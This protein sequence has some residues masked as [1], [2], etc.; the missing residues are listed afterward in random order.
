[1]KCQKCNNEIPDN[2]EFCPYCGQSQ[3]SKSAE[4]EKDFVC[5]YCGTEIEESTAYCPECGASFHHKINVELPVLPNRGLFLSSPN[6]PKII[7]AG[8]TAAAIVLS[9]FAYYI[10]IGSTSNITSSERTEITEEAKPANYDKNLLIGT[11][12]FDNVDGNTDDLYLFEEGVFTKYQIDT[13][14]GTPTLISKETGSTYS[15]DDLLI[16][17][18]AQNGS[19][20]KYKVESINDV[21]LVLSYGFLHSMSGKKI[22][23]PTFDQIINEAK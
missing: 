22:D 16:F 9:F 23:R 8:L 3:E 7:M 6:A 2:S 5:R 10:T 11:W 19:T 17:D 21:D 13:I 12:R 4:E 20:H 1:M 15:T 18:N 14:D